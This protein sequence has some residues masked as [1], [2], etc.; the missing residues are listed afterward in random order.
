MIWTRRNTRQV[1][2]L[3]MA[4]PALLL[5]LSGP[6]AWADE[7]HTEKEIYEKASVRNFDG[8]FLVFSD[9]QG[10]VLARALSDVLAIYVDSLPEL[11]EFNRAERAYLQQDYAAAVTAY[12]KALGRARSFWKDLVRIRCLR[13]CDVSGQ[14]DRAVEIYI[15]LAQTLADKADRFMPR[16]ARGA[17]A[18]AVPKALQLLADALPKIKDQGAYWQLEALRLSIL[19]ET[20]SDSAERAAREIMTKLH[21]GANPPSRY[22]LQMIAIRVEVKHGQYSVALEHI[23]PALKEADEEYL[24]ELLFLKGQCLYALAESR[25][26]LIRAALAFM[27]VVVHFPKSRLCA[28]SLYQVAQVYERIDRRSKALELY[29]SCREL[30]GAGAEVVASADAAIQRLQRVK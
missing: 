20:E 4:A 6:G 9:A 27:R 22:R 24:P 16:N 18:G 23:N 1:L 11:E 26:D 28:E 5:A 25:D 8:E 30:P 14:F 29:E 3:R 15:A 21:G 17:A 10:E 13:A 19:E 7:V 2:N 12:E